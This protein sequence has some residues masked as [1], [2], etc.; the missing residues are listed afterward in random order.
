MC[1]SSIFLSYNFFQEPYCLLEWW[2]THYWRKQLGVWDSKTDSVAGCRHMLQLHTWFLHWDAALRAALFARSPKAA[3]SAYL[4]FSY[5]KNDPFRCLGWILQFAAAWK[6]LAW[7]LL[8]FPNPF[9][10]ISGLKWKSR[11]MDY[12]YKYNGSSTATSRIGLCK[13]QVQIFTS[14]NILK[15]R[16]QK[17]EKIF[18]YVW[19]V[20]FLCVGTLLLGAA[21]KKKWEEVQRSAFT[22]VMLHIPDILCVF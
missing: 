15:G 7:L 14:G 20:P 6:H 4:T 16:N 9:C 13:Q 21:C 3:S 18:T 2:G 17:S 19:T 1:L 12:S 11:V 10:C 5:F 22:T 8:V